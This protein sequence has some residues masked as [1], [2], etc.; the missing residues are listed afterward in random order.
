MLR[1]AAAT[2]KIGWWSK[3]GHIMDAL[4]KGMVLDQSVATPLCGSTAGLEG[5]H[6]ARNRVTGRVRGQVK[7]L[8]KPKEMTVAAVDYQT[9]PNHSAG[10]FKLMVVDV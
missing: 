4:S 9:P 1:D 10:V 6:L 8:G 3:L 2:W 5:G 7:P